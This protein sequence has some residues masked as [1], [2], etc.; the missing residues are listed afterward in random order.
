MV[1]IFSLEPEYKKRLNP[2][3]LERLSDWQGRILRE[4]PQVGKL[5]REQLT[6]NL[7]TYL[8][9]G[10]K[11]EFSEC[12][13]DVAGWLRKCLDTGDTHFPYAYDTEVI[14]PMVRIES[15]IIEAYRRV[16]AERRR[17]EYDERWRAAFLSIEP[18]VDDAK[19]YLNTKEH[20]QFIL[21]M[22]KAI[23]TYLEEGKACLADARTSNYRWWLNE[24]QER[25]KKEARET[26]ATNKA[27]EYNHRLNQEMAELTAR[28]DQKQKDLGSYFRS[29]IKDRRYTSHNFDYVLSENDQKHFDDTLVSTANKRLERLCPEDL[30]LF[31]VLPCQYYRR[32]YPLPSAT[33][34]FEGVPSLDFSFDIFAVAYAEVRLKPTN[35]SLDGYK[36]LL[37]WIT[38][39]NGSPLL[40]EPKSLGYYYLV[41]RP[42]DLGGYVFWESI[43]L[44]LMK[45][46]LSGEAR[47]NGCA[48]SA[49][50]DSETTYKVQGFG[51]DVDV[52]DK[53]AEY[54]KSIGSMDKM[55]EMGVMTEKVGNIVKSA[56]SEMEVKQEALPAAEKAVRR[57]SMKER[58]FRLFDEGKRPGDPEVKALGIKP[59]SAYRY[60][61][62]WKKSASAANLGA[63]SVKNHSN[64]HSGKSR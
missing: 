19:K 15:L 61:Q 12:V 51:E 45:G 29:E 7:D 31:I 40:R 56:L 59:T 57:Q 55:I 2:H 47:P 64:N 24:I 54:L 43:P 30:R 4:A 13:A 11:V 63:V 34:S 22:G 9:D 16:E 25:K 17:K 14:D 20:D 3:A 1:E 28:L 62:E 33:Y 41:L 53:F 36:F 48:V 21:A 44:V 42:E 50:S 8:H 37:P 23:D 27:L 10:E 18:P 6:A 52:P 38:D 58:A 46:L 32:Y 39:E 60:Y 5:T 49:A 26:Q 35:V